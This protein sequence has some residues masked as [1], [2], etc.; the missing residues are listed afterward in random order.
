[1]IAAFVISAALFSSAPHAS[2]FWG[3]PIL[4]IVFLGL[5]ALTAVWVA[6]GMLRRDLPERRSGRR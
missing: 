5:A 2:T 1:M 3:Y 4:T 6:V